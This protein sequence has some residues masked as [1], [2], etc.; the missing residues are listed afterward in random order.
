M[1]RPTSLRGLLV[2]FV[3][4]AA[5]CACGSL[6]PIMGSSHSAGGTVV[7][8]AGDV[9]RYQV[10]T[11]ECSHDAGATLRL[12]GELLQTVYLAGTA[13]TVYLSAG[14]WNGAYGVLASDGSFDPLTASDCSWSLQLTPQ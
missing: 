2:A 6:S 3:I 13:G 7:V 1:R 8:Q 10:A 4:V 14:S 11:T 5:L 12:H 9:F